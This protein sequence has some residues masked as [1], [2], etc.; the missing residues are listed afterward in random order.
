MSKLSQ[1]KSR[2]IVETEN[3]V[4]DRR[5]Q[6]QIIL[7]LKPGYVIFRLKGTRASYA[8]SY[9][10]LLNYVIRMEALRKKAEKAKKW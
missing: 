2:L 8:G 1:R 4:Y 3:A 6:R 10:S 9:T 5:R 7:E